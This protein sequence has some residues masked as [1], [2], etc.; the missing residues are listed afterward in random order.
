MAE[1]FVHP[2]LATLLKADDLFRQI[3]S[4]PGESYREVK[5]RRTFRIKLADNYYFAK[6][7]YGVGWWEIIKNLLQLRLPVLGAATEWS[8]IQRLTALNVPTMVP[9]A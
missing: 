4:L 2:S 7:H 5:T 3:D 8:A 1:L 6:V 9:V